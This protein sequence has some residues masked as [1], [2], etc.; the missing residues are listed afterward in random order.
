MKCN[1]ILS[2]I[3]FIFLIGCT[4]KPLTLN[5][6][7]GFFPANKTVSQEDVRVKLPIKGKSGYQFVY[8]SQYIKPEL[9]DSI[10]ESY[11]TL[12]TQSLSQLNMGKVLN[13]KQFK[14]LMSQNGIDKKNV[15]FSNSGLTKLA[16]KVGPF[17]K[18]HIRLEA[19]NSE[20]DRYTIEVFDPVQG[21]EVFNVSTVPLILFTTEKD[22]IYPSINELIKWWEGQEN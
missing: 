18:I 21:K 7:T 17:L 16:K 11:R 5:K 4:V 15:S 8:L 10:Q 20:W 14:E 3:L 6:S 19:E 1:F 9:H 22:M 12:H 13:S 2:A